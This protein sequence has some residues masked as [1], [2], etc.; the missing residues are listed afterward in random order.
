MN[1]EAVYR[2]SVRSYQSLTGARVLPAEYI[3]TQD[4]RH[5]IG[6]D[7][8]ALQRALD[9]VAAL[10]SAVEVVRRGNN[11]R[12]SLQLFWRGMRPEDY[13]RQ[14]S[15]LGVG[16]E[17]PLNRSPRRAPEAALANEALAV[18][19]GNLVR[20]KRQLDLDLHEAEH[21]LFTARRQLDNSEVMLDAA[22]QRFEMDRL[23]LELGEISTREWLRRL[24][25]FRDIQRTHEILL[26]Q[27]HAAVAAHNQAVGDLL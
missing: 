12:P 8:P 5:E 24:S 6:E 10:S 13:A 9:E 20:L 18:A 17:V 27:Q 26:L 14:V 1:Q 2:D 11:F 23:A 3:E 25:E 16:F 4:S 7:H 19:Q 21:L 22:T 15:A